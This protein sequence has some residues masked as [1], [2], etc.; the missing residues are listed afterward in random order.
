MA[1]G[2]PPALRVADDSPGVADAR[3]PGIVAGA[4]AAYGLARLVATMLF[5]LSPTDPL[6]YGS[7]ALVLIAI[8]LLAAWLP[9]RRASRIDPTVAMTST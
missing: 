5:G 9:A 1:L 2:A 4:A 3:A 6:T 7:V 8:A